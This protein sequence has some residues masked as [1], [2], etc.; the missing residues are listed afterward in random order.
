MRLWIKYGSKN[1]SG[2]PLWWSWSHGGGALGTGL[3]SK[4]DRSAAYASGHAAKEYRSCR[5]GLK[6]CSCTGFPICNWCMMD[7]VSFILFETYELV[8]LKN[9]TLDP[10]LSKKFES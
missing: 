10:R 3:S 6:K 1:Y 2:I 9:E 8:R 5:T 4:V 7:P